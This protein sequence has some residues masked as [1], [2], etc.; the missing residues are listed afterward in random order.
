MAIV[1]K[2][3]GF[4]RDIA[5]I[6]ANDLSSDAQS[7]ALADFA[8][9]EID[10]TRVRNAEATGR[11]PDYEVTVDGRRGAPLDSVRPSGV[12]VAEFNLLLDLFAWVALQLDTH[13]PK[14][15]GRYAGSHVFFADGQEAE[16]LAAPDA[17]EYVF[18]NAQ[19]YAR[20]IENG[21]SR[22][23]PD[24]VYQTVAALAWRRYSNVARIGFGY[25]SMV[26]GAVGN[27]AGRTK[28]QSTAPSR[29]VV[30]SSRRRDWLTRQPAIII[31]PGR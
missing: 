3:E 5:F 11:L 7:A 6:V 13:S 14:R 8:Q 31:R 18:V 12:I 30:G 1:T 19:P 16:P 28:L 15:S 21:L 24:G 26:G 25:R 27:W 17:V 22:Q 23:A 2:I 9:D 20:K 4:D 10:D 29:N